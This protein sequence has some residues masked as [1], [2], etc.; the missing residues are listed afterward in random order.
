MGEFTLF[1]PKF[2][3]EATKKVRL[4]M[5]RL[6][7]NF[8]WQKTYAF[9]RKRDLEFNVG[10]WVYLKISPMKGVMRSRK[11]GTLIPRYVGP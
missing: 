3:Y 5:Q 6:R 8:C 7:T 9:N 4:I 2:V 1:G 10:D 11:K